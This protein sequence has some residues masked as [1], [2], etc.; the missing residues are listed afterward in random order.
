MERNDAKRVSLIKVSDVPNESG[1]PLVRIQIFGVGVGP[2]IPRNAADPVCDWL[3][4]CSQSGIDELQANLFDPLSEHD[5]GEVGA[6]GAEEPA[7]EAVAG[8]TPVTG[9]E[10]FHE[11][12]PAVAEYSG[13]GAENVEAAVAAAVEASVTSDPTEPEA[14]TA[15]SKE[16]LA[17]M[18]AAGL[19]LPAPYAEPAVAEVIKPE[20]QEVSVEAENTEV[21]AEETPKPTAE[22]PAEA[23]APEVTEPGEAPVLEEH[24]EP[25]P[26]APAEE[27]ALAEATE[28]VV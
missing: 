22:V 8:E 13:A 28:P 23:V 10:D 1:N 3:Q 11:W 17:E 24:A 15:Y 19:P 14:L 7:V 6:S 27:P 12:S 21:A 2:V 16:E 18:K 20:A 26:V 5:P 4:G 25:G 9:A